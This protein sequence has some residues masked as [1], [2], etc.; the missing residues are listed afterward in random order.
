MDQPR[1]REPDPGT[2]SVPRRTCSGL[3]TSVTSQ[4]V[5]DTP[6]VFSLT[7]L[8]TSY[9]VFSVRPPSLPLTSLLP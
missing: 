8:L 9:R 2:P 4:R 1:T 5:L 6:F 3:G 7:V